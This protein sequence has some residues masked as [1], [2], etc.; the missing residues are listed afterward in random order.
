M[1]SRRSETSDAEV[2]KGVTS[3]RA[4]MKLHDTSLLDI[5]HEPWWGLPTVCMTTTFPSVI[6]QQQVN[7]LSTGRSSA[8]R[9]CDGGS[10][11]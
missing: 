8:A 4:N 7:S 9:E 10:R 3:F 5:V 11:G 6:L 2:T 1:V